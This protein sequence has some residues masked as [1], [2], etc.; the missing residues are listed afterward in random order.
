MSIIQ[1]PE[2]DD[3]ICVNDSWRLAYNVTRVMTERIYIAL[4]TF[5]QASI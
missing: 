3:V 1:V 5:G 2:I 4:E